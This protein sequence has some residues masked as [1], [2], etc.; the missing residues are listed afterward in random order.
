MEKNLQNEEAEE[1]V[2]SKMKGLA[3]LYSVCGGIMIVLFVFSLLLIPFMCETLPQF[4]GVLCVCLVC[5]ANG[6]FC[7]IMLGQYN[8]T[9]DK[10]ITY[11]NGQLYLYQLKYDDL[12]RSGLQ[13]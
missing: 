11:K 4:M 12:Q 1:V 3:T 8:K 13:A 7:F 6:M 10:I 2:A 5:L 9:P